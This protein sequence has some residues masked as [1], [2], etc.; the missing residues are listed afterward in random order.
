[1]SVRV[2]D[3]DQGKLEVIEANKLLIRYTYERIIDKT[4]PKAERW[5]MPKSIWDATQHAHMCILLANSIRVTNKEEAKRRILLS[6][7]AIG[8]LDEVICLIDTCH[9]LGKIPENKANHWTDIATKA[10]TTAKGWLKSQRNTYA[11]FLD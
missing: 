1:M 5:I 9:V 2:G 7:E 11:E 10:Q 3:R 6:E 8:Y 4:F